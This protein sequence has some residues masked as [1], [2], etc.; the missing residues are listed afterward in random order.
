LRRD[1]LLIAA[2]ADRDCSGNVQIDL[3]AKG[4]PTKY[5]MPELWYLADALTGKASEYSRMDRPE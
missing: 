3:M 5:P 1:K 2:C 4:G